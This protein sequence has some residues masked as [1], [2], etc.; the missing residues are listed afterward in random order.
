M[1]EGCASKRTTVLFGVRQAV[2]FAY[3]KEAA[4][5]LFDADGSI[6]YAGEAVQQIMTLPLPDT[7][8]TALSLDCTRRLPVLG[9]L[10]I[11]TGINSHPY[12][13]TAS[14]ARL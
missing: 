11:P 4:K 8:A 12:R 2:S 3:S 1:S 14:L 6:L 9:L 10:P 7:A 13:F 5:G